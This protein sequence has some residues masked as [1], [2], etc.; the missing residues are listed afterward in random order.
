MPEIHKP[1][2]SGSISEFRK[3]AREAL[4]SG[5]NS[6]IRKPANS[7]VCIP[8]KRSFKE[9]LIEWFPN[10][11]RL[12]GISLSHDLIKSR[13]KKNLLLELSISS[14]RGN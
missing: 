4:Q 7:D 11:S 3:I 14:A 6:A 9:R 12:L 10:A 13:I 1:R 5:D 8:G 2:S